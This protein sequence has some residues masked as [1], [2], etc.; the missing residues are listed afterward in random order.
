MVHA[1][2]ASTHEAIVAWES[3]ATFVKE[4]EARAAL[5]ER[6]ARERVSRMEAESVTT[7]ASAHGEAEGFTRRIALLEGK[8]MDTR[9]AQDM[10]EANNRGL[11][12]V[13]A[14]VDRRWEEA[15]RES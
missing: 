9:Q 11:F 1:V 3:I 5:V 4:A 10:T 2:E 15:E 7:L 8:L 13:A 6:E 12:D 14:N